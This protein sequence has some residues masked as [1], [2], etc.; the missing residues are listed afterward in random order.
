MSHE[1]TALDLIPV[2]VAAIN[3]SEIIDEGSDL[4]RE[5]ATSG[6]DRPNS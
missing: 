2:R 3:A 6:V 1:L 5:L 4:W